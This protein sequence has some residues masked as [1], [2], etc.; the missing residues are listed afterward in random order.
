MRIIKRIV[1][2]LLAIIVVIATTG[3][4]F[5]EY[6]YSYEQSLDN[7]AKV[8]LCRYDY[9]TESIEIISVL[10]MDT[11]YALL[12][13]IASLSCY[14]PFGDHS[15]YYGDIV[16]YIS[17]TNGEAEVNGMGNSAAVD[18][19]GRWIMKGYYFDEAQWC[20]AV[21]NHVDSK[22]VPELKRYLE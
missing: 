18:M 11:A 8:E 17:Y 20:E 19:D 10:D 3:C 16:L 6:S 9:W 14:K 2:C 7:V 15:T 13:D 1:N 5:I 4:S 12:S 21:M 22:L